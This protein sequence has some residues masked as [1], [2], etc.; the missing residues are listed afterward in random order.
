MRNLF[1]KLILGAL[2]VVSVL[3][4]TPAPTRADPADRY[5]RHY[6]NWYDGTYR[7]Y[8]HRRYVVPPAAYVYPPAPVAPYGTYYAPAPPYYGGGVVVGPGVVRYGWW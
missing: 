2:L 5:W 4:L 7:P 8:Y 3:A 6:W 1:P